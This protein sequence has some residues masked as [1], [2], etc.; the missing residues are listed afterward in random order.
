MTRQVTYLIFLSVELIVF[1]SVTI[2]IVSLLYS[3]FMGAPYVPSKQ[4]NIDEILKAAN[5]KKNQL[6][7]ELGSGDG[8]VVRRAVKKYSVRGL[9][10]EINPLMV[11][12]AKFLAKFDKINHIEFKTGNIFETDFSCADVIYI[13][14]M[15]EII[16][17]LFS[18]FNQELKI[19]TLVISHGF[20][21]PQWEQK[22]IRTIKG[23]P[24]ATFFYQK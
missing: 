1:I 24:F 20:K 18:K 22:L 6:F 13:F 12:A 7:L 4:K 14:L 8:R 10:I 15:P 11:M 3:S 2:Y 9:G 23:E 21:I 17:R 19:N 5:L 16:R